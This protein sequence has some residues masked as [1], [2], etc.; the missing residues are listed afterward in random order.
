MVTRCGWF[1]DPAWPA[2]STTPGCRWRPISPSPTALHQAGT[3]LFRVM[4]DPPEGAVRRLRHSRPCGRA[5]RGRPTSISPRSNDHSPT[6]T[7]A[8]PRSSLRS[9]V[10]AAAPRTRRSVRA[11]PRGTRRWRRRTRTPP[12]RCGVWPTGTWSRPRSRSPTVARW[13]TTSPP[14]STSSRPRWPS[15]ESLANRVDRAV[16]D[17]AEAAL[18]ADRVG[19]TFDAVVIDEDQRGVIA[20]LRDPAVV[21]RVNANEVDPGQRDPGHGRV[22]GR[23]SPPGHPPPG[24]LTEYLPS[25]EY[26]ATE[27]PPPVLGQ[28]ASRR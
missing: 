14:R 18:L 20:Q 22:G 26:G 15:G 3:G 9:D 28:D 12:R 11:R 10:R 4:A 25:I 5:G 17:L 27:N 8:R 24:R 1:C 16:I 19:E 2:R 23:R 13:M 6:T 7:P 21:A